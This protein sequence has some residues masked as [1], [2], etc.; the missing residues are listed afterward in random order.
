MAVSIKDVARHADV[1]TTTVSVVL[2]NRT[3]EGRVSENT[4]QKVLSSVKK[5]GYI[6]NLYARSMR[7]G[8]TFTI[9]VIAPS[10]M[11]Y[12][13]SLIVKGASSEAVKSGYEIIVGISF[14]DSDREQAYIK[15]FLSRRVDGIIFSGHPSQATASILKNL[16]NNKFPLVIAG[17]L[18]SDG[19]DAISGD[20]EMSGY[21]ATNH[22]V[23]L[24]HKRIAFCIG[25]RSRFAVQG[26][27]P[28]GTAVSHVEVDSELATDV[29]RI[30]YHGYQRAIEN[31]GIQT[32]ELCIASETSD[33]EGGRESAATILKMKERPDGIVFR[34]DEMAAGALNFLLGAKIRVPEDISLVGIGNK[35]LTEM[36]LVPMTS[37]NYPSVEV[38]IKAIEIIM[39]NINDKKTKD[40]SEKINGVAQSIRLAPNLI[41]RSST[42]PRK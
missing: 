15:N 7:K 36:T 26:Y 21:E 19:I 1:S 22:L 31:S 6:S 2:N 18:V 24:G 27:S 33:Y 42:A 29:C 34:N 23:R 10:S 25:N 32:Q 20:P 30:R 12:Q 28:A 9:G 14:F 5:T 37:V 35:P 40:G 11:S 13:T 4:R 16:Y 38:G 8:S 39:K 17:S 41:I 3:K